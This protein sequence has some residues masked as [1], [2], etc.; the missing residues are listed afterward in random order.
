MCLVLYCIS[1]GIYIISYYDI[2]LHYII[3]HYIILYYIVLYYIILYC[4]LLYRNYSFAASFAFC[5]R[6]LRAWASMP[7]YEV[8]SVESE[9][10]LSKALKEN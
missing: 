1:Y 4:I 7:G 9:K 2:L 8:W 3:L 6:Q 10:K 5:D